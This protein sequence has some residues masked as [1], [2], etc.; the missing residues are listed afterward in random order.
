V[1]IHTALLRPAAA[2]SPNKNHVANARYG[3]LLNDGNETSPN[4]TA[5]N[6]EFPMPEKHPVPKFTAKRCIG[7]RGAGGDVEEARLCSLSAIPG[8]RRF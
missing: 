6:A 2:V 8:L 5:N 1:R 4:I 7:G 3:K